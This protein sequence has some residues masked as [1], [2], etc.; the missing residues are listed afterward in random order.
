MTDLVDTFTNLKAKV[1]DTIHIISM[2]DEPNYKDKEGVVQTIDDIGQ[3]HGTWG[4]CAII[5]GLDVYKIIKKG[6]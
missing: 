6:N 5:P 2:V 4:G 3:L 1:G